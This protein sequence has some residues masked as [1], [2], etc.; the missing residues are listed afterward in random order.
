MHSV[1]D[2]VDAAQVCAAAPQGLRETVETVLTQAAPEFLGGLMVVV[3]VAAVGW[4][5]RGGGRPRK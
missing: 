4:A 3:L 5:V 2:Q 1:P